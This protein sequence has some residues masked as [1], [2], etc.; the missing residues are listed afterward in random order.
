MIQMGV[1]LLSVLLDDIKK[2]LQKNEIKKID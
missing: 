1:N 2:I